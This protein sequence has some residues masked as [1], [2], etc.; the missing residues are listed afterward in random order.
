MTSPP[1]MDIRLEAMSPSVALALA[2][3]IA[4]IDPWRRLAVPA[5]RL[6]RQ[7]TPAPS[8][9][10]RLVAVAGAP[11]GAVVIRRNWLLGPY[12]QHLSVLPEAQG[13]GAGT[14]ALA[15]LDDIARSDGHKN[16]WLCVSGFNTGAAGFYRRHGFTAAADLQD[17]VRPGE[18]E[19]LMRRILP[20]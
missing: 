4:D 14:A 5:E 19:I 1:R 6:A 10:I 9:E 13:R 16:V 7:F 12:L 20:D 17:L 2:P 18:S 3:R 15:L 8:V 11:A